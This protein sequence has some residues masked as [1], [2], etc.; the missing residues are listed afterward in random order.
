MVLVHSGRSYTLLDANQPRRACSSEHASC[1]LVVQLMLCKFTFQCHW[2][3]QSRKLHSKAV[4]KVRER[5]RDKKDGEEDERCSF[6][7]SFEATKVDDGENR[8]IFFL[9]KDKSLQTELRP[10][11]GTKMQLVRSIEERRYSLLLSQMKLETSALY[12]L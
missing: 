8:K 2:L 6:V 10:S 5:E 3:L 9:D 4:G 12:Y 11:G 7:R 1:G